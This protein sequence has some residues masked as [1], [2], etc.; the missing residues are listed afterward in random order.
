MKTPLMVSLS[1]H[2]TSVPP[3]WILLHEKPAITKNIKLNDDHAA[4]G[5]DAGAFNL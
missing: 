1:N 4:F 3:W 2:A 5:K